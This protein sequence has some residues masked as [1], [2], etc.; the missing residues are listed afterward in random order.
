MEYVV[1]HGVVSDLYHVYFKRIL[2]TVVLCDGANY[3]VDGSVMASLI[4]SKK[5][6]KMYDDDIATH[7][8]RITGH[9]FFGR[10]TTNIT[11]CSFRMA[12]NLAFIRLMIL[13]KIHLVSI[14][15]W[16]CVYVV[17]DDDFVYLKIES[18]ARLLKYSLNNINSSTTTPRIV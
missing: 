11:F 9:L 13:F 17:A 15:R 10:S 16:W 7:E 4:G 5:L 3:F 12:W 14:Y 8:W 18:S 1:L 2:N 6:S